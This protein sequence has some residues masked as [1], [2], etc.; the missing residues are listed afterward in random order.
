MTIQE[1]INIIKSNLK[2]VKTERE[3]QSIAFIVTEHLFNYSKT[4]VLL[5]KSKEV[6]NITEQKFFHILSRLKK[7]E[8]L[9]YILE[10]TEFYGLS[11]KVNNN[12]LI[13]RQ[14]TEELVRWIIE[15]NKDR[16]NL[17]I[18]D[19]GTGS[20]C[21]AVAVAKNITNC[22]MIAIDNS[23]KVLAVATTNA[24]KNDVEI[25]FLNHDICKN[26]KLA[27]KQDIIISNPPYVRKKEKKLMPVNVLNYEPAS[28][29]FVD[30]NNPLKFYKAIIEFCKINLKDAGILYLEINES[31]HNETKN[32]LA[33]NNFININIRKDINGKFRMIK[34]IYEKK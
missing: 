21:I 30:D 2:N 31:L 34:A 33:D 13:P 11:F 24:L 22:R 18:T 15:D 7:D 4:E 27:N 10:Q 3:I 17:N 8:P 28:A 12:V 29:L 16:K 20:A 26:I 6:D 14:E 23:K 1:I 9:Q 5:N 25:V 19:I 32:I